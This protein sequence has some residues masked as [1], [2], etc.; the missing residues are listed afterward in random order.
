MTSRSRHVAALLAAVLVALTLGACGDRVDDRD[1]LLRYVAATSRLPARYVYVDERFADESL[2]IEARRTEVQGLREDDFRFKARVLFNGN[3]GFDEV[4]ADDTLA[5]RFLDPT[6]I[7]AFVN[8]EQAAKVDLKTD[9]EGV[10][11]VEALRS[12]R[13]VVDKSAA[14]S[15]T[16]GTR[17]VEDLGKDPVLDALTALQYVEQAVREAAGVERWSE[18]DLSPAYSASEDD[19]P[20]P[21]DG[22]GVIR[23]DL[24]RAPLPPASNLTGRDEDSFPSTKHF[25]RMS[26]YVKDERVIQVIEKVD[27]RGKK[28]DDFIRYNRAVLRANQVPAEVQAAFDEAVKLRPESATEEIAFG[29]GILAG[30]NI[31]LRAVG[32]DP[33]LVRNMRLDFRDLGGVIKVDLPLDEEVIGAEL[34]FLVVTDNGKIT[35]RKGEGGGT[36]ATSA[37]TT[38]ESAP[39]TSTP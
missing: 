32:N 22:S 39:P 4:V 14:P 38:S 8:K 35:E 19:F 29:Q 20:K 30:L 26:I 11:V 24:V 27:L 33:V 37:P 12:R 36:T 16:A 9:R 3:D 15:I 1:R 10:G 25:R 21:E 17:D 18:D 2:G 23:Y 34:D 13:W 28:L 7:N 5:M 31:T 6:T